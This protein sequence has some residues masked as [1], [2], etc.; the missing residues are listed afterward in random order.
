MKPFKKPIFGFSEQKFNNEE[1]RYLFDFFLIKNRTIDHVM[2]R[3]NALGIDN[4]WE[5]DREILKQSTC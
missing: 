3:I 4:I 2:D 5:I 1:F